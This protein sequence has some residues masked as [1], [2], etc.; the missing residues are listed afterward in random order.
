MLLC[1]VAFSRKALPAASPEI[2]VGRTLP[3]ESLLDEQGHPVALA[4]LRGNPTVLVFF[5]GALCVACRAQL[6]K[7]AD[8]AAPYLDRGVRL[9]GVSADPPAVSAEWKRTLKIPFP[10]LSDPH[11]ALA[12]A[13]CGQN[14]HCVVLVDSA[15]VVRWGALNDYWRGALP[16]ADVLIAARRLGAS[17]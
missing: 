12:Q 1:V 15:G 7:F 9:F 5:R 10:L 3:N 16:A 6:T 11:R 8:S 14:A 17:G 4:S 13:L 2:A